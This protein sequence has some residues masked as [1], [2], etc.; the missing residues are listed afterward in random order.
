LFPKETSKLF[1]FAAAKSIV[2]L[3]CQ[4][5]AFEKRDRPPEP[6]ERQ[7]VTQ[8]DDCCIPLVW[9]K[10]PTL[11]AHSRNG[12]ASKTW[13]LPADWPQVKNARLANVTVEG[14]CRDQ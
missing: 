14:I 4:K 3:A 7:R 6:T 10:E 5:F 12:Y 11:L 13:K 2:P 8:G 1:P 9:K